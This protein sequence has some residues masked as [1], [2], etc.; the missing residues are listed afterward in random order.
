VANY[1]YT[2]RDKNGILVEDSYTAENQKSVAVMLM[3]K[4]L[5]PI[6]IDELLP[7]TDLAE[8]FNRWQDRRSLQLDDI[9]LFSRQMY[10][11]LKAGV[12]IIRSIRSLEESSQNKALQSALGEIATSL[13]GGL[14]L[15][16]AM[17]EHSYIFSD[18]F[19]NIVKVGE[20]TGALDQGFLQISHYLGREKETIS[21][22]KS[23]TQYPKM[24]VI[25]LAIA[26]GI[27]TVY[28]IPA[29]KGVFEGLG[30]ELPWQTILL[31]N[32]SDFAIAYLPQIVVG[33]FLSLFLLKRYV[34]TTQGEMYKDMLILKIPGIGSIIHRSCM[35]RFSRSFAMILSAG[36]PIIQGITVVSGAIGNVYIGSKLSE[37]RIGIEKG[38]NISRMA[39]SVGLFS[40][41]VIQM[42]VVGEESGSIDEMLLEAADFYTSEV[43]A[44]LDALSTVIEPILLVIVGI[45][46]LILALGIFLPMWNLS[47]AM[48]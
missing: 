18:L 45:M 10:S 13:E 30:A 7:P 17:E 48:H 15:S 46:V 19:I 22:I 34:K 24:V 3:T 16:L 9:I 37:M 40:P 32:I 31:L 41:L 29:F 35:E 5:T 39:K 8:K 21:R 28:V 6:R 44:E 36:V 4:G 12:P 42:I 14:S 1:K 20:S 23:A 11:L 47:S 26:L 2:A 33:M 27:V 38:D 43:D 25:A